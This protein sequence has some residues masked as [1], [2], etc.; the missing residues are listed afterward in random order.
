MLIMK[1]TVAILAFF[2]AAVLAGVF[3]SNTLASASPATKE[4]FFQQ[5]K[6]MPVADAEVSGIGS[7]GA[8][9][10]STPAPLL[11]QPYEVANDNELYQFGNNK[12]GADCCPSPFSSD[13]G[14]ICLTES[15]KKEFGSRGGN[16]SA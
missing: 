12:V 7:T 3:V 1:R 11:A 5:E 6:G 2:V 4:K 9:L 15:Q 8:L 14:C 16:R 10:S 13:L